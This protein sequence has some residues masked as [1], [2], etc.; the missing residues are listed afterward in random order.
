MS[1]S[2]VLQAPPGGALG[3][4]DADI[5][6]LLSHSATGAFDSPPKYSCRECCKLRMSEVRLG[7]LMWSITP[8]VS[9]KQIQRLLEA[10]P[11]AAKLQQDYNPAGEVRARA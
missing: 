7:G 11:P 10:L 6:P 9:D 4:G 8:E 1:V 3:R 5:K 2:G